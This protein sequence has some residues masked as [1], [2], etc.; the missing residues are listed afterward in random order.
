VPTTRL[1]AQKSLT[2]QRILSSESGALSRTVGPL[3]H[4][5]QS[6]ATFPR[7]VQCQATRRR[8]TFAAFGQLVRAGWIC[9]GRSG[10]VEGGP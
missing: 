9:G 3:R 6:L 7:P 4:A 2:H 1:P 5:G 8:S 10:R